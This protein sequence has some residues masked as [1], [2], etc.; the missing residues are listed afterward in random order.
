MVGPTSWLSVLFLSVALS[1]A[2]AAA[3]EAAPPEVRVLIEKQLDAFARDDA[4]GAYALA[5]PGIKAIFPDSDTFM[6]MVRNSYA[7]VYR[8]RSVEFGDFVDDGE[9]GEQALTIVDEDNDVWTAVYLLARQPDGTWKTTGCILT[10]S[11]Q[12][13]L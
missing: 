3:G 8:H 6:E 4:E 11:K 9:K 1:A 13:S 12:S 5:A 7:P 10:K 2:R